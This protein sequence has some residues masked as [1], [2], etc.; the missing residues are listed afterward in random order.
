[1][2]PQIGSKLTLMTAERLLKLLALISIGTT[3]FAVLHWHQTG[4]A[5]SPFLLRLS[6]GAFA[7][8]LLVALLGRNTR[9]RMM[10][11]FLAAVCALL[12][13]VALVTDLSRAGGSST[14]LAEH[15]SQFTPSLLAATKSAIS[16][17]LG[18]GAWNALAMVLNLPS[19]AVFA[20]LAAIFGFAARPRQRIS[21]FVN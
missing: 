18:G 8:A 10:L 16:Q 15:F 20:L 9:P 2:G 14:T 17:Q 19:Y 4:L 21:V 11:R 7:A 5:P 1:M 12:A 3:A 13:V 6:A